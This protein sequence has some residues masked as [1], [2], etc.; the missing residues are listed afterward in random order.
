[1]FDHDY[2]SQVKTIKIFD[3]KW[4]SYF[5]CLS[6]LKNNNMNHVRFSVSKD[7]V[8]M[9]THDIVKSMAVM[10]VI[11]YVTCDNVTFLVL[12]LYTK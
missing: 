10:S 4:H 3:L 8:I 9:S 5:I 2:K 11:S 7:G 6:V 12:S 1:M